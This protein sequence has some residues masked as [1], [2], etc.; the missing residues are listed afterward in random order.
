MST[1]VFPMSSIDRPSFEG[2][3]TPTDRPHPSAVYADALVST[4]AA[5]L[6]TVRDISG[7]DSPPDTA[8]IVDAEAP[9]RA[10]I[11]NPQIHGVEYE[12]ALTDEGGVRPDHAPV[13][14]QIASQGFGL[15]PERIDSV[16]VNSSQAAGENAAPGEGRAGGEK[17]VHTDKGQGALDGAPTE[18]DGRAGH[19]TS[20]ETEG[21]VENAYLSHGRASE[22]SDDRPG[23]GNT[24]A[25]KETSEPTRD[26]GVGGRD[27]GYQKR[28]EGGIESAAVTGGAANLPT[29]GT[30]DSGRGQG[31]EYRSQFEDGNQNAEEGERSDGVVRLSEGVE[32]FADSPVLTPGEAQRRS[33]ALTNGEAVDTRMVPV[34][35]IAVTEDVRQLLRQYHAL[36]I[37]M[38]QLHPDEDPD[39]LLEQHPTVRAVT[40]E[41]LSIVELEKRRSGIVAEGHTT[42]T[43]QGAEKIGL[44][45]HM[46]GMVDR[47][48]QGPMG[49]FVIRWNVSLGDDT[50]G[51][52]GARGAAKFSQARSRAELEPMFA[53][54]R[55]VR[56]TF[57]PG[58]VNRLAPGCLHRGPG[59]GRQPG[60]RKGSRLLIMHTVR[61]RDLH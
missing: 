1:N 18:G 35:K 34:G 14:G 29:R 17:D 32:F 55:L 56:E 5:E 15:S 8:R 42:I 30:M 28:E 44:P 25:G 58:Y 22:V 41:F 50:V 16:A 54:G 7:A 33:D 46:D 51:T 3:P 47:T 2:A 52:V 11:A 31:D 60:E 19:E 43:F 38:G 59:G 27:A 26:D 24:T 45:W 53:D 23:E 21:P 37:R 10:G 36:R 40:D 49:R 39:E 20:P 12:E 4:S 9:P 13:L 48:D 6:S 57:G 61:M